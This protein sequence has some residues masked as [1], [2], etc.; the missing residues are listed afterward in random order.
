MESLNDEAL[1]SD[2]ALAIEYKW[3][4]DNKWVKCVA[5]V[6]TTY[7]LLLDGHVFYYH[8]NLD[9][10]NDVVLVLMIIITTFLWSYEMF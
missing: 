3:I 6:Y 1:Y 5:L 4:K 8:D 2:F 9:V 7:V 10:S